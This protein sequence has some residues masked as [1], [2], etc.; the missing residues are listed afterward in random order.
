[1]EVRASKVT[2][3]LDPEFGASFMNS[4]NYIEGLCLC[5]VAADVVLSG[6]NSDLDNAL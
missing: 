2:Y 6:P 1:M 3:R 5:L 4:W